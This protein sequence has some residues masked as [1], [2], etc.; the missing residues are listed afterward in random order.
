MNKDV[1]MDLSDEITQNEFI[2][3]MRNGEA[4]KKIAIR[5]R[6]SPNQS[7]Q[8]NYSAGSF[9]PHLRALHDQCER[10]TSL[11]LVRTLFRDNQTRVDALFLGFMH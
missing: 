6:A 5:E 8:E 9:I 2:N 11:S 3:K 1:V 7:D 10:S 4:I